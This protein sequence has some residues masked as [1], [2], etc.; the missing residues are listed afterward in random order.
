MVEF[1]DSSMKTEILVRDC[2]RNAE[3]LSK[4]RKDPTEQC[5]LLIISLRDLLIEVARDLDTLRSDLNNER[6]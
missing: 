6:Q 4:L 3:K 2:F 5:S 1:T